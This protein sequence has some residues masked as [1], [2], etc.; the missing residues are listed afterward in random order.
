MAQINI[1]N[2]IHC[3]IAENKFNA[4]KVLTLIRV[5]FIFRFSN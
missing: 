3:I 5:N 1:I 2:T 4:T